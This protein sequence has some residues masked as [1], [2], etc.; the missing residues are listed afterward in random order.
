MTAC[1]KQIAR[2]VELFCLERDIAL[3]A[4]GSTTFRNE[5]AE[6]GLEPDECYSRG[7]DKAIPDFAL[8]VVKTHGSLDKLE[9]YRGLGV[10]EVWIFQAGA[11]RVLGLQNERYELLATSA[12]L[13]EL[14]LALLARF[15]QRRDQHVA[16]KEFRDAIRS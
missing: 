1:K 10:R 2:F 15:V 16:L 9:V 13:A 6:R 3:F 11:F 4:Y 14:D 7:D 12:V 5:D 8:E